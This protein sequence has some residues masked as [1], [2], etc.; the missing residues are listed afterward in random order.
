MQARRFTSS[1]VNTG[2]TVLLLIYVGLDV[3]AAFSSDSYL[4]SN[5]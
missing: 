4:T 3:T 2:F 5:Q 1:A